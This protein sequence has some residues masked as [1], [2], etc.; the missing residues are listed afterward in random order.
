MICLKSITPPNMESCCHNASSI[1]GDIFS[2]HTSINMDNADYRQR[3]KSAHYSLV[4]D[5][6]GSGYSSGCPECVL[7]SP[8]WYFVRRE[9]RELLGGY[10]AVKALTSTR[11]SRTTFTLQE[12]VILQTTAVTGQSVIFIG[13]FSTYFLAMSTEVMEANPLLGSDVYNFTY[14]F[15]VAWLFLTIC[16]GFFLAQPMRKQL[17]EKVD[18]SWP[19]PRATAIVLKAL[20]S[21]SDSG[22]DSAV[23][24]LNKVT[25]ICIAWSWF[26]WLYGPAM[27]AWPIF[28]S[29]AAAR[30]H[31]TLDWSTAYIGSGMMLTRN[32][33][34]SMLL[35]AVVMFGVVS[36]IMDSVNCFSVTG[37][38]CP[39]G[40]DGLK[41][42]W[43]LPPL[44]ITVVDSLYELGKLALRG[45]RSLLRQ[46]AERPAAE[47]PEASLECSP[48]LEAAA[49]E[50]SRADSVNPPA[51]SVSIDVPTRIISLSAPHSSCSL[52]LTSNS[53]HSPL[54]PFMDAVNKDGNIGTRTEVVKNDQDLDKCER[55]AGQASETRERKGYEI[56]DW[57]PMA[58]YTLNGLLIVLLL[59]HLVHGIRWYQCLITLLVSPLVGYGVNV[60]AAETD[61]ALVSAVGKFV[62]ICM[63]DWVGTMNG[64]LFLAG[65]GMVTVG[66]SGDLLG[67]YKVAALCGTPPRKMLQ[68]QVIGAI[69]AVCVMPL[70]YRAFL[71]AFPITPAGNF[72]APGAVA[73]RALASMFTSGFGLLPPHVSL[74]VLAFALLAL[75]NNLVRD[76][77]PAAWRPYLPSSMGFVVGGYIAPAFGLNPFF[78]FL[79]A[80]AWRRSSPKSAAKLLPA[81]SAGMI[82]GEG[83]GATL[84]AFVTLAGCAPPAGMAISFA[85]L[86]R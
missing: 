8:Q 67:D 70:I 6:F 86:S 46:P 42:Y 45:V 23:S 81:L 82:A 38:P 55:D 22:A 25:L 85:G 47:R 13:G 12:N 60:G 39:A 50:V 30:Y 75:L 65:L 36:P 10:A 20:H 64:I 66:S 84:E 52:S 68:A 32:T 48:R 74:L 73:L 49:F 24:S 18:Y 40:F 26:K 44:A 15:A 56:P 28:G 78:G 72:T 51:S 54:P 2:M 76:F 34:Y 9:R 53:P 27:E 14:P 62:I 77:G 79:I 80:E 21:G 69:P 83:I 29:V 16:L 5:W 71:A 63:G 33:A 1:P 3:S 37:E 59:P 4:G 11:L 43:F 57:F 58:G 7:W 41:A 17:V 31:W 35:G 61:V 19:T